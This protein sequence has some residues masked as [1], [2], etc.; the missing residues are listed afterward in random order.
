MYDHDNHISTMP[1][2][3]FL[4]AL[5]LIPLICA[6]SATYAIDALSPVE[7]FLGSDYDAD[8]YS[9][10]DL[11]QQKRFAP[12]SPGDSDLGDQLILKRYGKRDPFRVDL[13]SL[14]YWS[15]NMA[16]ASNNE[17]DGFIWQS[18]LLASWKPRIGGGYF[19]DIT[20]SQSI[21]RYDNASFLDFERTDFRIGLVKIA[22][23]FFD[24]LFFARYEYARITSGSLSD[25]IYDDHRVRIGAHKVFLSNAT[26]TAYLAIDYS[27]DLSASLSFLERNEYNT[28]LG[29][30]Y[31]VTDRLRA[32]LYY[33][34]SIYDYDLAGREDYNHIL[35]AELYWQ[36]SHSTRLHT[37]FTYVKN[38]SNLASGRA[39]YTSKQGGIGFGFTKTF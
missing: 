30:T 36:L 29:Y 28:H 10:L 22:P 8:E 17:D 15:D 39:D 1:K 20:A 7:R 33:N 32:I 34:L 21:Y 13:S 18:R 24:I 25:D 14:L 2:K 3:S 31:Q 11:N 27:H 5:F 19:S 16:N 38:N 23:D 26:H 4:P 37:S 12:E 35:G 9:D 6:S